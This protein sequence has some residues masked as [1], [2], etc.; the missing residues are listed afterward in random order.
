MPARRFSRTRATLAGALTGLA[1]AMAG[2]AA[3]MLLHERPPGGLAPQ[4]AVIIALLSG[5]LMF[6]LLFAF[7]TAAAM[8]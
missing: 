7:V 6:G 3:V 1:L 8:V 5:S 2:V 4:P